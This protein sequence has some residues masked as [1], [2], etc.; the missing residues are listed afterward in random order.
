MPHCSHTMNLRVE[1][2]MLSPGLHL[3][4]GSFELWRNL[5]LCFTLHHQLH[6]KNCLAWQIWVM[7]SSDWALE[8]LFDCCAG[9]LN[10]EGPGFVAHWSY[11]ESVQ[12]ELWVWTGPWIFLST[13]ETSSELWRTCLCGSLTTHNA[14]NQRLSRAEASFRELT[15]IYVKLPICFTAHTQTACELSYLRVFGLGPGS[16]H[17][18]LTLKYEESGIVAHCSYIETCRLSHGCEIQACAF[19]VKTL[20]YEEPHCSLLTHNEPGSWVVD[21][22]SVRSKS[23]HWVPTGSSHTSHQSDLSQSSASTPDVLDRNTNIKAE[24]RW[25]PVATLC[26]STAWVSYQRVDV[27]HVAHTAWDVPEWGSVALDLHCYPSPLFCSL[28]GPIFCSLDGPKFVGWRPLP[29]HNNILPPNVCTEGPNFVSS[30]HVKIFNFGLPPIRVQY[31]QTYGLWLETGWGWLSPQWPNQEPPVWSERR[32]CGPCFAGLGQGFRGC[33]FIAVFWELALVMLQ[34]AL[35]ITSVGD[36]STSSLVAK[37][38]ANLQ[39]LSRQW[40][41]YHWEK[42]CFCNAFPGMF[43]TKTTLI[44]IFS[45]KSHRGNF[46]LHSF[47]HLTQNN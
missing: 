36:G 40:C 7:G 33:C 29:T 22:E 18:K 16:S 11:T 44:I 30:L 32:Y 3:F 5:P 35:K 2:W 34:I 43:L 14:Q 9:C 23:Q 21:A 19:S 8:F 12:V 26:L 45:K 39:I 42:A 4:S 17:R 46:F 38:L 31:V 13:A 20:N 24:E 28:D 41:L 1:L 25:V 6:T 27:S 47:C 10:D 15:S 37:M